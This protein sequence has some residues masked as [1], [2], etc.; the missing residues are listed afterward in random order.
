MSENAR[1]GLIV[2]A[3]LAVGPVALLGLLRLLRFAAVNAFAWALMRPGVRYDG[4]RWQ[5]VRGYVLDRDSGQC[6][7]CTRSYRQMDV[8]HR[9]PVSLGGNHQTW[10]LDTLCRACHEQIHPH[11]GKRG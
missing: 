11:M 1:L 8:H 6:R 2:F 5:V 10:N 7:R 9:Q 4:W 3:G